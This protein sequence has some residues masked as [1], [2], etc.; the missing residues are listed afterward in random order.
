M[1][2]GDLAVSVRPHYIVVLEGV[3]VT[4][5]KVEDEKRH[6]WSHPHFTTHWHWLDT[7]LRRLATNKRRFPDFGAE[8]V[9]FISEEAADQAAAFL[10]AMPLPYDSLQYV[11]LDQ[12]C[13]LLPYREGLQ[14]VYD[15]DP[16][17]LDR[18]GQLGR[19]VIRGEDYT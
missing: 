4:V 9:T 18:Y 8:I 11:S 1:E 13:S 17:R 7:P 6:R 12:F 2:H 14:V 16:Q 5:E 15:S 3:L 10:D 19:E